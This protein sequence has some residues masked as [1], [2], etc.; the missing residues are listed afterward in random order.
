MKLWHYRTFGGHRQ[1]RAGKTT[2]SKELGKH[3]FLPVI[4]RDEIK[5]GY[6]HVLSKAALE[7]P[8]DTNRIA[9]EVYFDTISRLLTANVSLMLKQHFNIGYGNH[10]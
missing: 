1:A 10:N 9:S 4:S 5:E 6:V 7:L 8:E 2:F 3:L